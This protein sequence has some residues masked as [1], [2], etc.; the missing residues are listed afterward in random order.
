[1]RYTATIILMILNLRLALAHD[2]DTIHL[3]KSHY[4]SLYTGFSKS[5][6]RDD[7][8]SPFKYRGHSVPIEIS[9]RYNST[10]CR[11]IFYANF[12]NT[13]LTSSLPNYENTGLNHYMK[14]TNIQIGYSYLR[15]SF[16]SDKYQSD[17]Y[18][19]GEINSLLNL[20]QQAYINNNEF[21]MLDQFNSLG[22]KVLLEKRFANNK[23]VAFVSLNIPLVSYVLMGDTYNAYVGKKIDPLV[24]Y[25]GNMLFY[26][27]KK[28][29]FVSFNHLVC[30]KT[31][32]SF[33]HF[34]GSHIGVEGKYSLRY[35]K[36]SQY[37]EI[38]FSKNLQ[39]QFLIG[40]VCKL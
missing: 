23:H 11:Q 21:L 17:L 29:D 24:N 20:R 6:E 2:A 4:F 31:D 3:D 9:Y 25:S 27:A 16:T 26:L 36:L 34:I 19:G 14:G 22:F 28:G 38:N 12:D 37:Q 10:K 18:F 30:F 5:I 1:M 32:F 15:R 39:N 7:A 35:Y 8:M 13:E 33:V 40:I